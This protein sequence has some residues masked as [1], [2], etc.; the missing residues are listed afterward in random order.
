MEV[1]ARKGSHAGRRTAG[2]CVKRAGET[3]PEAQHAEAARP[4]SRGRRRRR[5]RRAPRW[6]SPASSSCGR[7][8][9]RGEHRLHRGVAERRVRAGPAPVGALERRL[10]RAQRRRRARLRRARDEHGRA[11]GAAADQPVDARAHDR[12]WKHH[13]RARRLARDALGDAGGARP[14][15]RP[16]RS[17]RRARPGVSATSTPAAPA[18][19]RTSAASAAAS[20]PP[21]ASTTTR[22]AP[23]ARTSAARL[24]AVVAHEAGEVR[25]PAGYQRSG[26]PAAEAAREARVA[27]AERDVQDPRLVEQRDR[28][29]APA[30]SIVPISAEVC[31]STIAMRAASPAAR[32][33]RPGRRPPRRAR[34]S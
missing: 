17:P 4:W 30:E 15:A 25:R 5:R 18:A 32:G 6:R 14:V 3:A 20:S 8:P 11:R 7:A 23:A 21:S 10:E 1:M 29:R 22:R 24:R 26:S 19:R 34:R 16:R 28:A 12:V 31:V 33:A 27:R 9:Q 13:A 2:S